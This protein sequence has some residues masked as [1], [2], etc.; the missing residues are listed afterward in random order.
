MSNA[1]PLAH[2]RALLERVPLIDGHNDLPWVVRC[3]PE[4]RGDVVAARLD[5]NRQGRDTDIPRLKAGGVAGQFWAAFIPTDIPHPARATFEQID[6]IRRMEAAYP[7]SFLPARRPGDLARAKREGRIASFIAVEG[8]VGLENSLDLLRSFYDLGARYMT[9]C[10]N[11]TIDWVD[12]TTDAPRHG[13]LS[14][15][16]VRVVREMNRLG[17]MVD[18]SHTSHDAMRKVLDVTRAPVLFTHCNAFAL[19][20]HP[21]NVPDDVLDRIPANGGIVMATFVPDFVSQASRDWMRPMKDEWGKTRRGVDWHAAMQ[22]RREQLGPWPRASIPE[23]CDHIE[24]MANRAG[25]RHIGIGSDF[26]GGPPVVGLEDVSRFP[27]LVA[28]LV[29]RGWSDEALEG[30]LS[31][32]FLRVFRKVEAVGRLLRRTEKP[33]VGRLA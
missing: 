3:D 7:E 4:A 5:E 22:A 32:N 27:H 31:G 30:L 20:D 29:R 13:G 12:S 33:D 6:L 24:Y 8:G 25:L 17:M 15:F 26:F 16:G 14:D 19:C 23:L 1:D 2:A 21:R 10:H 9:L 28:E 18:C 11:E